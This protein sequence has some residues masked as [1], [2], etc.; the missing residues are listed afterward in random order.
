MKT[1][2]YILSA[3]VAMF[4]ISASAQQVTTLYFLENAPMRHTI[5][6][7]FQPVSRGYINFT[8]L[9]WMEMSIGNNSLTM[10]DALYTIDDPA[11]PGQKKTVTMLYPGT[12]RQ[13]F[14][15]QLHSM[16]YFN[17]DMNIGLL[18][19]GFRVKE[20]G[21]V[22]IGIN[23]RIEMGETTPKTLFS[24]LLGGGFTDL[25]GGINTLSLSGMGQGLTVYTEVSGKSC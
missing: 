14:L 25:S 13:K 20:K 7:A 23:E 4:A 12:D 5:N 2:K 6:P 11:N 18:N 15:K 8:P 22:T 9:G 19:M 1:K 10:S 24:T 3:L 21:Y 17:G 16:L